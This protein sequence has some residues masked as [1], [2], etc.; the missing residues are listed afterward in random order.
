[1]TVY[2]QELARARANVVA[3]RLIGAHDW[4]RLENVC[5]VCGMDWNHWKRGKTT[6]QIEAELYRCGATSRIGTGENV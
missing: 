1:M 2:D 3:C 5:K 6:E 4:P